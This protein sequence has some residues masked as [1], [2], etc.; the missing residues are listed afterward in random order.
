MNKE[1]DNRNAV[2]L[3]KSLIFSILQLCW[4]KQ[5][6]DTRV[7]M[8]KCAYGFETCNYVFNIF[9][10]EKK[11]IVNLQYYAFNPDILS[12]L[13][14]RNL[15]KQMEKWIWKFLIK[16]QLAFWN[17]YIMCWLRYKRMLCSCTF[18]LSELFYY[19]L[20]DNKY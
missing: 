17:T 20:S 5:D 12:P 19:H 4:A 7:T 1:P 9:S 16:M 18:S 10:I 2:S 8:Q 11:T 3:T 6:D 15:N 14:C 13:W